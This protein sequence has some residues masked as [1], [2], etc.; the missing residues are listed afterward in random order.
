MQSNLKV[1][2][3]KIVLHPIELN[4]SLQFSGDAINFLP[5]VTGAQ[6]APGTVLCCGRC[7]FSD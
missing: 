7:G 2:Y 4:V 6:P 3:S 5:Q 1:Y